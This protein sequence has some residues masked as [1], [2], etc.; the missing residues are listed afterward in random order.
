MTNYPV[1]DFLIRLKNAALADISEI[2][3]VSS[4]LIEGVAD[5]LKDASFLRSVEKDKKNLVV[6]L[7]YYKKSPV[8]EDIKIVSKPGLRIYIDCDELEKRKSP[9]ILILT[10]PKGVMTD[11]KAKKLRI[12]GEVI[13]RIL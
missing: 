3:V 7:A 2:S 13:A 6:R 12:G 5:A 4:K 8:I 11:K 10:T 9:E 1:A